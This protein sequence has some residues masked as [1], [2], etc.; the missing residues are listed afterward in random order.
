[1]VPNVMVYPFESAEGE[2]LKMLSPFQIEMA[3][4]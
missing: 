1:V 3:E 2:A 4:G